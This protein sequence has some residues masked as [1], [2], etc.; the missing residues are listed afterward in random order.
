MFITPQELNTVA[1][2]YQ[3]HELTNGNADITA[4]AISAG[5]EEAASYL[6][7]NHKTAWRDGRILYDV[8]AIFNATGT[9]RNAAIL[10]CTKSIALWYLVRLCNA[11]VIYEQVKERYDRAIAWLQKV[12]DGNATL[13]LPLLS[14]P[15]DGTEKKP[16]RFGSRT[17]FNHE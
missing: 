4:M 14:P 3:V 1:D 9:N 12:A 5:I 10:E 15:Q 16:F 2:A 6:R 11:D 13:S 8:D 7:P 17:K